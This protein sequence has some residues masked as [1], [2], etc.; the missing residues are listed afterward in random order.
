MSG[1]GERVLVVAPGWVGD[2][3]MCQSL[4]MTLRARWAR[5][6]ID[7]L[8]PAWACP[9]LERME[10]VDR[11]LEAPAGHGRLDPVGQ[12][13]TARAVRRTRYTRAIVTRRSFKSALIP[14]LAGVPVRTG[15]RGEARYGLINDLREVDSRSHPAAV[16]RLV[17]LGLEPGS[18]PGPAGVAWPRLRV[19]SAAGAALEAALGL[20][21][22]S[23]VVGLAPGAAFGPAK[24]WPQRYWQELGARLVERGRRVWIFG[25][26]AEAA[27]G[28]AIA[29]AAG[30]GAVSLC[31]RTG[32]GDVVD[33][34][35]RCDQVVSNDSGLM[36]L[37]AAS[38]PRVVALFGSTSPLNTPPLDARAAVIWHKLECSPCYARTCPLG[39]LRCLEGIAVDEVLDHLEDAGLRP[40]AGGGPHE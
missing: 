18:S 6:R 17:A 26:E 27:E 4:F 19:D 7:V 9:L 36:H 22:D 31:G 8:A 21:G 3:V 13:R 32:L 1:A 24:R 10:E 23:P 11:V 25:S 38:G 37:A 40:V 39:H 30:P 29:R 20:D 33:L 28:E 12:L 14:F 15:V 5:A 2:L 34:M 35:S 16:E